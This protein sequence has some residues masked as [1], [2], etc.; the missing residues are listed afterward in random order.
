MEAV[1]VSKQLWD[2]V[3]GGKTR[4]VR[5]ENLKP[6]KNFVRKQAEAHAKLVLGVKSSQLPHLCNLY[7]AMIWEDLKNIHKA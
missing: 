7:P 5:N 2:I 6:I 3:N 4:P 1:L